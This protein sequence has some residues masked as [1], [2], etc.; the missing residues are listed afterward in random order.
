MNYPWVYSVHK[1]CLKVL[2]YF[3][4]DIGPIFSQIVFHGLNIKIGN[5]RQLSTPIEGFKRV[6]VKISDR[7][8]AL[9]SKTTKHWKKLIILSISSIILLRYTKTPSPLNKNR[10]LTFS[11]IIDGFRKCWFFILTLLNNICFSKLIN[12][13][14][15]FP[16]SHFNSPYVYRILYLIIVIL[17]F[18]DIVLLNF[19]EQLV[20]VFVYFQLSLLNQPLRVTLMNFWKFFDIIFYYFPILFFNL[21]SSHIKLMTSL[22]ASWATN[23]NNGL[24]ALGHPHWLRLQL[25]TAKLLDL[26]LLLPATTLPQFQMWVQLLRNTVERFHFVSLQNASIYAFIVFFHTEFALFN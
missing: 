19:C 16:T 17:N 12:N 23:S 15:L 5:C 18:V 8:D 11:L 25:A 26:A 3:Q 1:L 24:H 4:V 20:C 14:T 6:L 7:F 13:K 22:D 10:F 21:Y 9:R 2:S